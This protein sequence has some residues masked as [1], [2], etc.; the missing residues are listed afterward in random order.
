MPQR[1]GGLLSI[2]E[3]EPALSERLVWPIFNQRLAQVSTGDGASSW[4]VS[5]EHLRGAETSTLPSPPPASLSPAVEPVRIALCDDDPLAQIAVG[6]MLRSAD[7]LRVVGIASGT[8]EIV[9]LAESKRPDVVVLDWMMPDGGGRE[10]ARRILDRRPETVIVALTASDSLEA[11]AE[12]TSAGATCLVA[13]GGSAA[14]LTGTIARALKKTAAARDARPQRGPG[15]PGRPGRRRIGVGVTARTAT[16]GGDLLDAAGALRLQSEFGPLGLLDELVS[17][18]ASQTP[19]RLRDLRRA[20]AT[21]DATAVAAGAHQLRGGCLTLAAAHMAERCYELEVA[22][23]EGQ[24]GG[25][26]D[27]IDEIESDFRL[28]HVALEALVRTAPHD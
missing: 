13:K 12:M 16:P 22:A 2:S 5:F 1:S 7:W 8:R 26:E 6:A 10:A 4:T 17:L 19:A 24:L 9:D 15:R 28:T 20:T 3:I 27:F 21:G 25:A 14:Q 11:L 23:G 18:F